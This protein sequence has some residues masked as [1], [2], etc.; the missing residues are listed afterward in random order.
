MI[1]ATL[2]Q[3]A[4][5]TSGRLADSAD[6]TLAVQGVG[7]DTRL[8]LGQRLFVALK[9]PNFDAHAFVGDAAGQG[10][11]AA[12]VEWEVPGVDLPQVVVEDCHRAL[13]A[14]ARAWRDRVDPEIVAITGSSGK[15]TVKEMLAAMLSQ[16]GPTSATRGNLNNDIGVP[17]TLLEWPPET[18]YAVVEMGANH[19][20]EIAG[21]TELVAP[22]VV[23]VTMAGRAHV[24]EFGSIERIIEAKGEI[25]RHCPRTSRAV[26]NLDSPGADDWLAAAANAETFT[27]QASRADR[28]TWYGR[29]L[30]GRHSLEI[31]ERGEDLLGPLVVPMPG[32]HNAVNLLAAISVARMVGLQ[33]VDIEAGLAIFE[34]PAGRMTTVRLANGWRVIDDSYNANPESMRAALAHLAAMAGTRVAV[35]GSMGELGEQSG[36]LHRDL[37]AEAAAAG[38]DRVLAVGP[39]AESTRAGF[40]EAGGDDRG[41]ICVPD[42]ETAAV[43]LGELL[44]DVG[45]NADVTVLLK[46][47]RFMHIERVRDALEREHGTAT[48]SGDNFTGR[49]PDAALAD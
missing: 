46:G 21:L 24:G 3:I 17:L 49:G 44:S 38:L 41:L 4:D 19:V 42:A 15:T 35:L 9:G 25:Y 45:G 6:A 20:G 28:A 47:S 29:Y 7:T 37:G 32:E 33:P 34:A 1:R 30:V 18:R 39:E 27:M 12:L 22:D 48:G 5:W 11:A 16:V 40:L 10:A 36:V 14:L 8:D 2:E 43:T 26:V 23:L 31:R 13:S